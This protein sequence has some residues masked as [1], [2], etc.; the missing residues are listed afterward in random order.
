MTCG[1]F[2]ARAGREFSEG[3]QGIFWPGQGIHQPEQGIGNQVRLA[4]DCNRGPT[5]RNDAMGQPGLNL[6]TS[7][8]FARSSRRRKPSAR[9]RMAAVRWLVG[10]TIFLIG[11]AKIVASPTVPGEAKLRPPDSISLMGPVSRVTPIHATTRARPCSYSPAQ[12]PGS[13]LAPQI[14]LP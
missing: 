11:R 4:S 13:F 1:K 5:A 7:I 10:E 2:P 3:G 8:G 9:S 6:A 12:S 14:S